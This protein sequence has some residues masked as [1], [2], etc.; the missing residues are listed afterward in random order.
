M[1]IEV[2]API[3][4]I[5]NLG[6]FTITDTGQF[7]Y[8][9][10]Q[11]INEPDLLSIVSHYENNQQ[12]NYSNMKSYYRGYHK[13]ILDKPAKDAY[14]PDNRIIVN[15]PRKA[16]IDFNGFFIGNRVK[17]DSPED[18][19]D[20]LISEW[21]QQN[22]FEDILLEVSKECSEFGHS[23]LL[24]YQDI[25]G[26]T[27]VTNCDPINTFLIYENTQSRKPKYAVQ[28]SY[29][30][31]GQE[32]ITLYDDTYIRTF[33]QDGTGLN[34]LRLD[35]SILNPY[36]TIPV[37]EFLE[38]SDRLALCADILSLIDALDK[39]MSEKANDVDYFADAYMKMIN[40]NL[41]EKSL[42]KLRDS[43]L[44]NV[45][46]NQANGQPDVGFLQKPS[47]DETQEHLIDRLVSSI[48]NIAGITNMNDSSFSGNVTGVALQMKFKPMQNMAKAKSLKFT[49]SLRQVFQCVFALN[50]SVSSDAWSQLSFQFTQNVPTNTQ[51]VISLLN[52]GFG[53]LPLDV[54]YR[55]IPF[56]D[57]PEQAVKDFK[58]E[59]Q[60]GQQAVQG[61]ME[62]RDDSQSGDE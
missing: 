34:G 28:F 25:D 30:N 2:E 17:I 51:D 58:D 52:A 29:N 21:T 53:K 38:N 37:I 35:S 10:D 57:D 23:Y 47:A 46:G 44:I 49:A 27:C 31:Q 6:N 9:Y 42:E 56:I 59:Q 45:K 15:F 24:V 54:L 3:G 39:A 33:V 48:Y 1:P 22:N 19:V 50:P 8:P 4:Q 16:V 43:R 36:Q 20:Q 26:N 18:N 7:L 40:V 32:I 13:A 5:T 12:N 62:P 60:E 14:K 41:D 11:E 61:L 55:Q